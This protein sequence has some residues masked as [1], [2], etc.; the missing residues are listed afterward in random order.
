LDPTDGIPPDRIALI[1]RGRDAAK[2][3]LATIFD[4]VNAQPVKVS[5]VLA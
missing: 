3:A 2:A 4:T 1:A 5:C